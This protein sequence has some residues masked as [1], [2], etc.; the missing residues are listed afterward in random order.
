MHMSHFLGGGP[1]GMVFNNL[2]DSID[3]EDLVSGFIQ[4]H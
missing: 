1:F 3:L 2:W 4:L